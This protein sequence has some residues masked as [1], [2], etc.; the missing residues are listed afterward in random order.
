MRDTPVQ[1]PGLLPGVRLGTWCRLLAFIAALLAGAELPSAQ[2][3]AAGEG[4][5]AVVDADVI[6]VA[7]F[8]QSFA[9]EGVAVLTD[10]SLTPEARDEAFRSMLLAGFDTYGGA[11]FALGRGWRVATPSQRDEFVALFRQELFRM[12]KQLFEGYEGEVLEVRRVRPFGPGKFMVETKLSNPDARISDIEF[13]VRKSGARLR[14]VDVRLEGFSLLETY[15]TEF[16][17]PLFRGGVERV[18]Q[19]LRPREAF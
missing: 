13:L 12:G 19:L 9:A 14:I 6:A 1:V 3:S 18:L 16:V 10:G 7:R 17:G 5:A 4:R 8:V 2:P 11:R 15:R